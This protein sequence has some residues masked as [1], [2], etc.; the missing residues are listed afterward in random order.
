MTG[1]QGSSRALRE[2]CLHGL[3]EGLS[4]LPLLERAET[5]WANLARLADH[6]DTANGRVALMTPKTSATQASRLTACW[7]RADGRVTPGANMVGYSS[8]MMS[9]SPRRVVNTATEP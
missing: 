9:L 5:I 2:K 8:R 1:A 7:V 3:G 6:G 4:T